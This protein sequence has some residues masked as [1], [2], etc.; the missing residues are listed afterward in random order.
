[1]SSDGRF[2]VFVSQAQDLVPE[3]VPFG[4][5]Q[6]YLRD[7]MAGTTTLI[8]INSAGTGGGNNS[9]RLGT[10]SADG[11]FV[12]FVSDANDL[13]TIPVTFMRSHVYVRDTCI[14]APGGCAP[15][16]TLV[17][18]DSA[19]TAEGN[20]GSG[21]SP[22]VMNDD[23]RFVAFDSLATNLVATA[24]NN[25]V[26]DMFVRDLVAGATTLVSVNAAGT[27]TGNAQSGLLG[28]ASVSISAD[29]NRIAFLSFAT[30]LVPGGVPTQQQNAFVR[31]LYPHDGLRRDGDLHLRCLRRRA[32]RHGHRHR[33]GGGQPARR[34][35]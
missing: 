22:I 10:I 17:S 15:S 5:N 11:R 1:M 4:V 28:P 32:V 29:G 16:T 21:G 9:S 23:G 18:V 25:G 19:G 3:P 30:D 6:V 27:S 35:R 24:D 31:D 20:G 34:R 12:A 7:R 33:R 14:G 13:V 8:S 2:V 26:A